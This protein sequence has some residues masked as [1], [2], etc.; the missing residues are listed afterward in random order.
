MPTHVSDPQWASEQVTAKPLWQ[1]PTGLGFSI[2]LHPPGGRPTQACIKPEEA[3]HLAEWLLWHVGD[4]PVPADPDRVRQAV[5]DARAALAAR[6]ATA[7]VSEEYRTGLA[8]C[9][10]WLGVI[11]TAADG[12]PS[13]DA[14]E[15][16]DMP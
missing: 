8:W 4:R 2:H 9:D 7:D 1:D 16:K 6:S 13:T 5:D 10:H 15:R 12:G 3:R 11:S 14:E